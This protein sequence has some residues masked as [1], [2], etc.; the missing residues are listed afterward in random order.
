[1][2]TD[3]TEH[4][5]NEFFG[6]RRGRQNIQALRQRVHLSARALLASPE[7]LIRPLALGNLFFQLLVG[8]QKLAGSLRDTLIEFFCDTFLLAQES[9][10]LQS[11]HCLVRR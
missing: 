9:C 11:D 10:L 7:L 5:A 2:A 6:F 4:L 8:S 3:G 1:E